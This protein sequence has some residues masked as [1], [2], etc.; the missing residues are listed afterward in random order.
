[1]RHHSLIRLPTLSSDELEQRSGALPAAEKQVEKLIDKRIVERKRVTGQ[2]QTGHL[3]EQSLFKTGSRSLNDEGIQTKRLLSGVFQGQHAAEGHAHEG[4]RFQ[5]VPIQELYE[6]LNQVGQAKAATQSEAVILTPKLVTDNA[7]TAGQQAC[8]RSEQIKASRQP[9]NQHERRPFSPLTISC[10]V[11][12][13]ICAAGSTCLGS[14]LRT[15]QSQPF[16]RNLHQ[17]LLTF[18]PRDVCSLQFFKQSPVTTV[19]EACV[20]PKVQ[21]RGKGKGFS[22]LIS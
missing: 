16:T 21:G 3:L 20:I 1:M 2:D 9:W 14:K 5:L 10:G 4:W 7:M 19:V 11:V 22:E 13:Q 6:I 17:I 18:L 12:L 8:Q 15:C